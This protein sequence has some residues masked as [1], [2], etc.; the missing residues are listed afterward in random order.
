[1]DYRKRQQQKSFSPRY[2]V[3]HM[4]VHMYITHFIIDLIQHLVCTHF[5]DN[6]MEQSEVKEKHVSAAIMQNKRKISGKNRTRTNFQ[7]DVA[8]MQ[9]VLRVQNGENIKVHSQK[10][11]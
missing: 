5:Y 4:Y 11:I 9:A 3:I 2:A 6:L 8:Q 7:V 1:M 10:K